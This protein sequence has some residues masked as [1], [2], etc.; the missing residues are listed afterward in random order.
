MRSEGHM[1]MD[2]LLVS[3]RAAARMCGVS[4]SHFY[5]LQSAGR[6]PMPIK[7]GRATRYPVTEIREWVEA[8]C[9]PRDRWLVLKGGAK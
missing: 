9:P 6:T 7:L 3:P 4:K 5:S 1:D 2:V 8:G